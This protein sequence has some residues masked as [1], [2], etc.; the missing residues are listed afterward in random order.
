VPI[1]LDRTH[2]SE[3]AYSF[4]RGGHKIEDILNLEKE[5]SD[6]KENIF[7]ITFIDRVDNIAQRDDGLSA[8]QP[9]DKENIEKII[10]NFKEISQ[11]S[12]F[13]NIIID[14]EGK[15]EDEVFEEILKKML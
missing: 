2:F 5:F 6:L 12:I 8:F 11:K 3:Y 9:K 13:K 4:F 15:D 1:I 14:I 10:N 7:I